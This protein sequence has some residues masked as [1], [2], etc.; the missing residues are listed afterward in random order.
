MRHTQRASEVS[1]RMA[2]TRG[3][4]ASFS[5]WI[6][7][8]AV[9]T[10]RKCSR[11]TLIE[12]LVVIAIIA[13]LAALLLPAL[14]QARERA[15]MAQC[16]SNF[17]QLGTTMALYQNDFRSIANEVTGKNWWAHIYIHYSGLPLIYEWT[18][19]DPVKMNNYLL[20]YTMSCPSF[21][22]GMGI[23]PSQASKQ[24]RAY[25]Y[26]GHVTKFAPFNWDG[27]KWDY[28]LNPRLY[29]RFSKWFIVMEANSTNAFLF[30]N[31]CVPKGQ[32]DAQRHNGGQNMLFMDGHV[33]YYK[34]LPGLMD[35]KLGWD[36]D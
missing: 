25:Q 3:C 19:Q 14:N 4:A 27:S 17:K 10:G 1:G 29:K 34:G 35:R 31:E 2:A 33:E 20:K 24:R 9:K 6:E 12:L 21:I 15:K 13:I 8:L 26:N 28:F 5:E 22:P 7:L 30:L 36:P 18:Y 23:I 11:F 16:M 32:A